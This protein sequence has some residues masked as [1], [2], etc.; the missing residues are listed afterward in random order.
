MIILDNS[1]PEKIKVI[2]GYKVYGELGTLQKN[3]CVH[4]IN[5]NAFKVIVEDI[6][7]ESWFS[8]EKYMFT[9][10]TYVFNA[11]EANLVSTMEIDAHN[12][13]KFYIRNSGMD[14]SHTHRIRRVFVK[15]ENEKT[16]Y[17]KDKEF[18]TYIEYLKTEYRKT[19]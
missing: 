2:P 6:G 4:I 14:F 5:D 18:N 1:R 3:L 19:L 15:M 8:S 17:G 12:S 7:F 13:M 10:M 9:N 16:Y 11:N